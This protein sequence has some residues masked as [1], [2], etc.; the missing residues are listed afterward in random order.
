MSDTFITKEIL[1][2]NGNPK[3]IQV[4]VA[5]DAYRPNPSWRGIEYGWT[6]D[7]VAP[8][9]ID[10][11]WRQDIADWVVSHGGVVVARRVD[12]DNE[13]VPLV[14]TA[15]HSLL[16]VVFDKEPEPKHWQQWSQDSGIDKEQV[17]LHRVIHDGNSVR[18]KFSLMS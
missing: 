11:N 9:S 12:I 15:N 7:D 14:Y 5:G 18:H 16:F 4:K 1:D 13:E 17:L 3:T 6:I 8:E 2:K 10:G